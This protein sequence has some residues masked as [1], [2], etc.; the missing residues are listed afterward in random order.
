MLKLSMSQWNSAQ[1]LSGGLT[2]PTP[3]VTSTSIPFYGVGVSKLSL[4]TLFLRHFCSSLIKP[5]SGIFSMLLT[6]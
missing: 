3:L 5:F 4:I 1:Y 2:V 6:H